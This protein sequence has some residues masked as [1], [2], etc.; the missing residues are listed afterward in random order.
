MQWRAIDRS[1]KLYNY[2]WSDGIFRASRTS[3]SKVQSLLPPG[4]VF[5]RRVPEAS[6]Q[7]VVEWTM[8]GGGSNNSLVSVDGR[9]GDVDGIGMEI[10]GVIQAFEVVTGMWKA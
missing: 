10:E 2:W 1:G 6:L 4:G 7:K 3:I 8:M 9:Y 5:S